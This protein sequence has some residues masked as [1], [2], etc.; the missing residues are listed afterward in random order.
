MKEKIIIAADPAGKGLKDQVKLHLVS[1]GFEVFDVGS[2]DNQEVPYYEAGYAVGKA[3]SEQAFPRGILFCSSGMGVSIVANKFPG[4]YCGLVESLETALLCRM[5]NNCNV[6]S[7]GERIVTP[8]K[9][10]RI[11]DAFLDTPFASPTSGFAPDFLKKACAQIH[12][13]EEALSAHSA[14]GLTPDR[15]KSGS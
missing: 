9:A 7:L 1:R 5:I 10:V 15:H 14:A 11:V 3:V 6:L 2:T 12:S 13:Y 4:V 8:Y